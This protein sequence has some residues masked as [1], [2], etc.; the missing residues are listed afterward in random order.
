[1]EKNTKNW[2]TNYVVSVFY[3]FAILFLIPSLMIVFVCIVNLLGT[4]QIGFGDRKGLIQIALCVICFIF[5]RGISSRKSYAY[6]YAIPFS[7]LMFLL[8][9]YMGYCSVSSNKYYLKAFGGDDPMVFFS[10]VVLQIL[11]FLFLANVY[12]LTRPEVK[13][14]FK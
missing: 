2:Q 12:F 5:A 7:I 8:G 6:K 10:G 4:G 13:E 14:Q 1:M 3:L 11:S 9:E